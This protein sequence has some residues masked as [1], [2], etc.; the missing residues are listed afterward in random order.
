[1]ILSLLFS[2]H[3]ARLLIIQLIVPIVQITFFCL[4]IGRQPRN[5]SVGYVDEEANMN[6]K[7]NANT[8][9]QQQHHPFLLGQMLIERI[10]NE[11]TLIRSYDKFDQ[12]YEDLKRGRVWSLIRVEKNFT[13]A[14]FNTI[15]NKRCNSGKPEEPPET[16]R[17][18]ADR[19]LF[20]R[21]IRIYS[22]NSSNAQLN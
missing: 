16:S 2:S 6:A 12:G 5:L 9:H 17:S 4:C 21:F 22:D 14:F 11:T 10:S 15:A 1:M 7:A 13:S 3:L 8:T 19:E 20:S 18:T